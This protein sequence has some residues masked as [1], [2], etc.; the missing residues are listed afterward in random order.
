MNIARP[1]EN[2]SSQF[3]SDPNASSPPRTLAR[4]AVP[5][6]FQANPARLPSSFQ[7]NFQDLAFHFEPGHH[8]HR[9]RTGS[10]EQA[11]LGQDHQYGHT[12]KPGSYEMAVRSQEKPTSLVFPAIGP[13]SGTISVTRAFEGHLPLLLLQSRIPPSP[14]GSFLFR[15]RC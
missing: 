8:D 10:V 9:I 13:G 11:T 2:R 5:P 1:E 12:W 7:T 6:Q 14:S 15:S 4:A 3:L